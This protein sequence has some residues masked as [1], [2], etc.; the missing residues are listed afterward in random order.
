[1]NINKFTIALIAISAVAAPVAAAT[2][3][4]PNGYIGVT[5]KGVKHWIP[6][7]DQHTKAWFQKWLENERKHGREYEFDSK[8]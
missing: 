3:P 7:Q 2:N 1:M 6:P 5:T 8:G 4:K